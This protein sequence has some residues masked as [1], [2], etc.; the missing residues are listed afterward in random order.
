MGKLDFWK[1][2]NKVRGPFTVTAAQEDKFS[3]RVTL[4]FN[5]GPKKTIQ[6]EKPNPVFMT[7]AV[8]TSSASVRPRLQ[9]KALVLKQKDHLL[10]PRKQEETSVELELA[11][12]S[13][14]GRSRAELGQQKSWSLFNPNSYMVSLRLELSVID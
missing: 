2:W 12:T 8:L 7:L 3:G 14:K 9:K 11:G 13:G 4:E 5:L 6:Q 1:Q 10:D